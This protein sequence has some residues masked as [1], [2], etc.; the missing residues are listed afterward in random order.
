MCTNYTPSARDQ[1]VAMRLGFDQLPAKE[2]PA[3]VFPGYE[4]PLVLAD[5]ADAT[6]G[7]RC[8]LARFGLVPRWS[9]DAQQAKEMS[10]HTLNARSETVADKPSF[11][12][13][14]R[15]RHYAL[16]PMQNFY[17]PCWE[18]AAA[19]AKSVRW[20]LAQANGEAFAAAA[21]WERWTDGGSGEITTSFSLLT[22]NAD[23]HPL[24]RR[25]HRPGDEKRSLVLVAPADYRAWLQ[26]TPE[27]AQSLLRC[28]GADSLVGEP[29]PRAPLRK[30]AAP[31]RWDQTPDLWR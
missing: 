30:A 16:A 6:G 7:A 25:M 26:A 20:R 17:E 28:P 4:A 18:A 24:L 1:L 2:W 19:S 8:V 21:L 23:A 11:R 9:R 22:V 15:E 10:R 12:G 14:W 27:Q 3:E 29:A 5:G 13:P 31:Q